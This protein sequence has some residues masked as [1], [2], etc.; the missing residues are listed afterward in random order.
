MRINTLEAYSWLSKTITLNDDGSYTKQPYP[1]VRRFTSHSFDVNT[2]DELAEVIQHAANNGHTLLKGELSKELNNESR[3]GATRANQP[4]QWICLDID[5]D[6]ALSTSPSDLLT[7]FHPALA[8]VDYIIQYSASDGISTKPGT[9]F[10]LFVMLD[11]PVLPSILKQ[12]LIAT[13]LQIPELERRLSLSANGAS[14]KFPIDVSVCQ[15]DKLLFVAPPTCVGFE[16]PISERIKIVHQGKK[17]ADI[18][19]ILVHAEK[20][21]EMIATAVNKLRETAGLPKKKPKAKQ[22]GNIDVMLNPDR[23]TVTGVQEGRGYT[24]LNL[25]GGDSWAYFFPENNPT[26]LYNFKG[27]QPVFLRD[28]VPDFYYALVGEIEKSNEKRPFA[29]RDA[30]SDTYYNGVYCPK[31]DNIELLS[32]VGSKDRISDFLAQ[33]GL[34]MP[35]TIFDWKLEFNPQT[36]TVFSPDK[37][38]VNL[39]NPTKF[40]RDKGTASPNR[41]PPTINKVLQSICVNQE[42]YDHFLNWLAVIFQKRIKTGTAWIFHGVPGTGKGLLLEKILQPLLGP[43]H[44]PMITAQQLED[45]FN[46]YMQTALITWLDEIKLDARNADQI[47]DKLKG[48]ITERN[49]TIRAMRQNPVQIM[50]YVNLILATNHPDPIPISSVDR[51]FN[52]AP[53]QESRINIA[54]SEVSLIEDELKLFAAYLRE[55]PINVALA[56]KVLESEARNLMIESS[57]KSIDTVFKAFRE[58]DIDYFADFLTDKPRLTT[59][60]SYIDFEQAVKRWCVD[61]IK[62]E[63]TSVTRDELMAVYA[64]LQGAHNIT[65]TKFSRICS[66]Q[67]IPLERTMLDGARTKRAITN[68]KTDDPDALLKSLDSR[69]VTPIKGLTKNAG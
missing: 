56:S 11:K 3:A 8:G 16:D 19:N 10:H 13:N 20:N 15:N 29:F 9:R 14:L 1:N 41:I 25:N 22:I 40:M 35:E 52:V 61:A 54:Y 55:Y 21:E 46:G 60:A 45:Q 48:M 49:I 69:N 57:E 50:N 18:S 67:R 38:W 64:Y 42:T 68:F 37:K 34:P 47:I 28:I 36:D 23:A 62:G 59:G 4:T 66:N 58:G 63:T 51:R 65:A 44:C 17:L 2:V 24:Y 33:Y 7:Q 32:P 27:E 31:T 39:F 5:T 30:S 12:W 53:A 43:Q 26:I 6:E